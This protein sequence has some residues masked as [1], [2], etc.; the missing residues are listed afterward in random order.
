LNEILPRVCG[1]NDE[2]CTINYIGLVPYLIKAVQELSTL[3]GILSTK[4]DT[5]NAKNDIL[6]SRL[7]QFEV[8]MQSLEK[9]AT[10]ND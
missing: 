6:E 10:W 7:N 8:R 4:N 1:I 9:L 2:C 3:N 5:L